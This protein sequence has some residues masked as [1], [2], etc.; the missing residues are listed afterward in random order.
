MTSDLLQNY[1]WHPKFLFIKFVQNI[2][3]YSWT[4]STNSHLWALQRPHLLVWPPDSPYIQSDY[5]K[6]SKTA[7]SPQRQ[8]L[9]KDVPTV[10]ITFSQRPVK[11]Q[12]ANGVHKTPFF[13]WTWLRNLFH[14]ARR[15]SL[16]LFGFSL[17][18]I[19]WFCYI[20]TRNNKNFRGQKCC[21]PQI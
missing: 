11:Q 19:F 12:L 14:T 18:D 20:L 9:L 4:W 3:N 2:V 8:Q 7:T 17:I 6:L 13:Y 10:K 21:I 1:C 16:Y 5:F 15:W